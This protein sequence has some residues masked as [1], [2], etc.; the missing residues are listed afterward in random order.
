MQLFPTVWGQSSL[1]YSLTYATWFTPIGEWLQQ[2]QSSRIH[3]LEDKVA[4]LL[5]IRK[6]TWHTQD[7]S[8]GKGIKMKHNACENY[9]AQGNVCCGI[10]VSAPPHY[11]TES[12]NSTQFLLTI[13]WVSQLPADHSGIWHI[14]P[15]VTHCAVRV[16]DTDLH[17]AL[18]Y[19][20][21][22]H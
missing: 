1:N 9:I 13:S 12:I 21:T 4:P 17:P 2:E 14:P 7:S 16:V 10:Y 5:L 19:I 11:C 20:S 22:I 18:S 8:T 15:V 6:W 3:P